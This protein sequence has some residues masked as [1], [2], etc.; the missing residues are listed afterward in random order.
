M[1]K[2]LLLLSRLK[3]VE[4]NLSNIGKSNESSNLFIPL[5][6][7]V[8]VSLI[9][10]QFQVHLLE[11]HHHQNHQTGCG[12]IKGDTSITHQCSEYS[13]IKCFCTTVK[14]NKVIIKWLP[15]QYRY[16]YLDGGGTLIDVLKYLIWY[17]TSTI[18]YLVNTNI[19]KLVNSK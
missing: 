17:S 7:V 1:S 18:I 6:N 13:F 2:V 4:S 9:L 11:L 15:L 8:F 16:L 5:S 3:L 10:Y 12:T 14:S 19:S